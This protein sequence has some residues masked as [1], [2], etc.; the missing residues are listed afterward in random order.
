M[1]HRLHPKFGS[2]PIEV[3][4]TRIKEGTRLRTFILITVLTLY[5]SYI[6]GKGLLLPRRKWIHQPFDVSELPSSF[7]VSS[8]VSV[9]FGC[10][11]WYVDGEQV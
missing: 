3:S 11:W 1:I 2:K 6:I 10:T 4:T 7:L 8:T 9:D 5:L